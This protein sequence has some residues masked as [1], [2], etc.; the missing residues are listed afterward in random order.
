MTEEK[1]L[2]LL[3]HGEDFTV[4][5]KECTNGLNN[6]VFETVAS[7]SN[8]YGGYLLLGVREDGDSTTVTG[9]NRNAVSSIK[10]NFINTLNNPSKINPPLYLNLE[11]FE[12]DGRIILWTYI[13]V[14]SQV[15]FCDK[16]IFDRNGDADQ[17]ITNSTDLAA[18]VFTRKSAAYSERRIFPFA[19]ISHLKTELLPRIRNMAAARRADHPW[20]YMN[21]MELLKN[22]G[23]YEENILT[24]EKGFNL[25]AIL[26]LGR[27]EIIRSACPGYRTDAVY[28]NTQPDRYDDRLI[29]ET[30][31][32]DSYDLLME[33]IA[34]HTND[35]FFLVNNMNVSV[36]DIIAREI[37]S[38][39]LVH[40][41]YASAF[42]AKLVITP[43]RITTENWNR[44]RY[45]G[46]IDPYSFIPY[47]KNPILSRF[48][49]NIVLTDALES[50]VRN[51]YK[52][53]KIYSGSEPDLE[54]RDIFRL[55]VP[56]KKEDSSSIRYEP[57]GWKNH[58]GKIMENPQT[59]YE[60]RN[61]VKKHR[62]HYDR[63]TA[64][65][66]F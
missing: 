9:V 62:L 40:R 1:I 18:A 45:P 12:I 5:Y 27:D 21:D 32:I 24:G 29:V 16:R 41:E 30:N 50:G 60:P 13:P 54:E 28:R 46:R 10:K 6:S 7:F 63:K 65:W 35:S 43:D 61:R 31:L 49:M 51:L 53:T 2:A 64:K 58:P 19:E 34:K 3:N 33:F 42:P 25:A 26:L 55:S 8:R 47:P 17:D 57:A 23:L 59:G 14:S 22:A 4:E 20:K 56:L 15:E 44:S 52:Y 37:V 36:R 38:N 66:S 48:F 11:E 39:I